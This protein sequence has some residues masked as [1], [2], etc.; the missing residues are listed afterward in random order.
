MAVEVA[1]G[2]RHEQRVADGQVADERGLG[3]GGG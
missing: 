2:A 3:L 1:P